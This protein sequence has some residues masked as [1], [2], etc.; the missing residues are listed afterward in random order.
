MPIPTKPKGRT[1][2]FDCEARPLSFW[3]PD[4]PTTEITAIC[5]AWAD[6]IEGT[7]HTC[8]LGETSMK[9]MLAYFV[10]R[11]NEA[12]MVTGHY[13]IRFDLPLVNAALVENGMETLTEKM[14][15]DTKQHLIKYRFLPKTQEHLSDMMG[16]VR[17]KEHMKQSEWREANRLTPAG[18]AETR[19]RVEGDVRQ[20]YELRAELI[21]RNLLKPPSLW[22]P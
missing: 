1:L 14:A 5:S 9:D 4:Q 16:T 15:S 3:V 21:R 12:T 6:D 10:E 2:H 7:I 13:I 20:H 11:Y 17:D 8:L 18:L 22:R 19:R